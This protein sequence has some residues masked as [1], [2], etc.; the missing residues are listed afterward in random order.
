[1]SLD[2]NAITK[3]HIEKLAQI[4]ALAARKSEVAANSCCAEAN[5]GGASADTSDEEIMRATLLDRAMADLNFERAKLMSALAGLRA[6]YEGQSNPRFLLAEA[7]KLDEI[8]VIE[9]A[10]ADRREQIKVLGQTGALTDASAEG[11]DTS[12]NEIRSLFSKIEGQLDAAR[13][14]A[15]DLN[16]RRSSSTRWKRTLIR[17]RTFWK[18][19]AAR[20]K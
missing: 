4:D 11:D 5:S 12:V 15:R 8:A 14:E 1:M 17:H 10:L 20:S 18:K 13:L 2:K 6:G 16:R 9:K 19:R 7:A 3:A